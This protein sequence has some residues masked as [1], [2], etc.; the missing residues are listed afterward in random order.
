MLTHRY[1][2]T[3]KIILLT[4]HIVLDIVIFAQYPITC[5]LTATALMRSPFRGAVHRG[6]PYVTIQ[7]GEHDADETE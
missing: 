2:I 4:L 7:A 6:P 1:H 5:G 3:Y